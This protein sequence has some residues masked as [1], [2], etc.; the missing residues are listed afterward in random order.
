MMCATFSVLGGVIGE[1]KVRAWGL[2][3]YPLLGN[4]N[5][6]AFGI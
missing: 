5:E 6:Q 4:I 2:A 1:M 3:G